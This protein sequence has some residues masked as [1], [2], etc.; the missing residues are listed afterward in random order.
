[1][2]WD[3]QKYLC[4][5]NFSTFSHTFSL[6]IF[7][8]ILLL[9]A[10][11]KCLRISFL[12]MFYWGIRWKEMCNVKSLLKSW[13]LSKIKHLCKDNVLKNLAK[14][15]AKNS[16]SECQTFQAGVLRPYSKETLAQVVSYK[17]CEIFKN[18]SFTEKLRNTVSVN[19]PGES[20]TLNL[21]YFWRNYFWNISF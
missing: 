4:S 7:I 11:Q 1:M 20:T 21:N 9:L 6:F 19:G 16:V 14:F 18:I 8:L 13:N 10:W 15:T 2:S 5:T 12:G 17:F 3:L